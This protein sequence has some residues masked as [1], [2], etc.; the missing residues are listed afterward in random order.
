MFCG[1]IYPYSVVICC[2]NTLFNFS[3][4][5]KDLT[6]TCMS[7]DTWPYQRA[8]LRTVCIQIKRTQTWTI[9]FFLLAPYPVLYWELVVL[10]QSYLMG[11]DL[12]MVHLAMPLVSLWP[13]TQLVTAMNSCSV[14]SSLSRTFSLSWKESKSAKKQQLLSWLYLVFSIMT[15]T[16][17]TTPYYHPGWAENRSKT[18]I[19]LQFQKFKRAHKPH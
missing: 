5:A 4:Q 13:A 8:W 10:P 6:A 17:M 14:S 2:N 7:Y 18:V 11:L 3:H 1:C 9:T 15:S 16:I 12:D 19:S